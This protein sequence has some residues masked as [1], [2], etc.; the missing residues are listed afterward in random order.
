MQMGR[1]ETNSAQHR[2]GVST[3]LYTQDVDPHQRFL[4][5]KR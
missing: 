1:R 2:D 4:A 3:G 5:V